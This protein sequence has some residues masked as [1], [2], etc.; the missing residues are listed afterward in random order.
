MQ[1]QNDA[2]RWPPDHAGKSA[3]RSLPEW[4]LVAPR[5]FVERPHRTFLALSI[6]ILGSLIAEPLT[7]L[8][9]TA[10][11]AQLGVDE[12]A[13]LGV[14]AMVLSAVFW[15]FAFLG[16]A[17]QTRVAELLGAA[18]GDATGGPRAKAARMCWVAVALALLLG[19]GLALAGFLTAGAA[20]R[21]M[22]ASGAV[23]DLSASYLRVR[24]TGAP[25][26]LACFAAFG[27]LRG[28]HDMRTP[29][30]VAAGIN[31]FNI[32][33]DPLLIFGFG[34]VP[35]FGVAGAAAASAVSQWMGAGWAAV[36]AVR[37]LGRPTAFDWHLARGL[38]SAGVDLF[39]RAACLNAFLLLGTRKATLSG[40]SAGAVHQVVRSTWFFSALFL[41]SFAIAAQSLVA[42]FLG[43]AQPARAKRVAGVAVQW[44]VG[45]G[46][47]I[48]LLML[49][50]EPA[51]RQVYV[52]A[53][54]AAL[55]FTPW[56]I[57]A[58]LQPLSGVTF[59]TDG[60]H[61]GSG[62][63]AFL[64]NAVIAALAA[65]SLI[66]LGVDSRSDAALETV[67]WAFAAWS[68][69]RAALGALRV[70]PGFGRA[71]LA[72]RDEA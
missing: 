37:R 29:L 35:G 62:D 10:F 27:A 4:G 7:G 67:W 46:A 6:P 65:G 44:S 28:A 50:C 36:A 16:V 31:A 30:W 19:S 22:G 33:L 14:G 15:A 38:L 61:F 40:A 56:R 3:V 51:V 2:H 9:D 5:L 43:G 66:L 12:L 48:G 59:A 11:V 18:Q 68:G 42:H 25:G 49:A 8:V 21:A 60:V 39:L 54:A 55:F 70:W 52:P 1:A 34:P 72:T 17:T 69:V 57:A 45:A 47:G 13:A 71:P 32:L 23:A 24:L 26:M 63:F 41:D 20:S 64:R 58:G 53:A